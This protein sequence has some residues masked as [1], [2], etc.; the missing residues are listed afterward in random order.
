MLNMEKIKPYISMFTLIIN[1]SVCFMMNYIFIAIIIFGSVT[2][3]EPTTSVLIFEII[4]S[5][6][7]TIS[8]SIQFVKKLRKMGEKI[9][10]K[11]P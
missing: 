11:N 1:V 8:L 7:C 6:F 10:V 5:T 2:I 9:N 3:L 4:I